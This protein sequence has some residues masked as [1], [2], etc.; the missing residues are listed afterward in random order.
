MT[1]ILDDIGPYLQAGGLGTLGTDILYI[2]IPPQAPDNCLL[3]TPYGGS[4]ADLVMKVQDPNLQVRVR[5][6]NSGLAYNTALQVMDLLTVQNATIGETYY[7]EIRALSNPL[8]MGTDA[9]NRYE[10]S[11]NFSILK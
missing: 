11:V 9:K 10:F 6:L 8:P 7:T 1:N 2:A 5:N 4:H 3:L